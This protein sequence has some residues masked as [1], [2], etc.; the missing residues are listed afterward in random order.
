[1]CIYPYV[2]VLMYIDTPMEYGCVYTKLLIVVSP[3][4]LDGMGRW[5][6]GL[7]E[8]FLVFTLYSAIIFQ[9]L[10]QFKKQI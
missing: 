1:M 6:G 5:E 8:E 3:K 2:C 9:I 10:K 7:L 4:E